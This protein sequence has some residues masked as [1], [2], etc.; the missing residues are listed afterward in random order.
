MKRIKHFAGT[1]ILLLVY[2]I[3]LA[4][5]A[6]AL[7]ADAEIPI[8]WNAKGVI[9]GYAPKSTAIFLAV[10]L[11]PGLFLFLYLMPYYSPRYKRQ[12]QRFDRVLPYISFV[13]VLFLALLNIYGLCYSLGA[14]RLPF[15]PVLIIIGFLMMFLGNLLPKLPR[16]FF[17]GIRTPWTISDEDNWHRTHRVGART[18]L[19]GG[20]LL[21]IKG[22]LS[23]NPAWQIAS[24][25][26]ALALLLYPL[27][28]S[29][30]LFKKK[31]R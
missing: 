2:L 16:N 18:F 15:N 31:S 13:L 14:D 12:A 20:L 23:L 6:Q 22:F 3:A 29:L 7:P 25:W 19:L 1:V 10:L 4:F 30:Y 5:I 11:V 9:D 17:V 27:P 21:I 26:L 8:H 28:Y 24:S